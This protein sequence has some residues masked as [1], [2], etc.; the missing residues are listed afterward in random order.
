MSVTTKPSTPSPTIESEPAGDRFVAGALWTV[1]GLLVILQ[2]VAGEIIP[3]L[4]IAG[5]VYAGLGIL[6]ARR[7]SRRL[8]AAVI[9][10]GVIHLAGSA[11]FMLANLSHPE[12]TV[13]FLSEAFLGLAGMVVLIGAVAGLR[14]DRPGARRPIA[15]GAGLLAAAAVVVSLAAAS[16]VESEALGRGDVPV[17]TVRSAFP[18]IEVPAGGAVL[19]VDNQDP[20]H[21]TLVIE[22]TDVRAVLPG[23]TAVRVEVD[24][25]PGTYRYFCDVPGHDS[26][27][28]VLH[29]L[30]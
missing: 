5:L 29:V 2:V 7:R 3:P 8:L 25:E 28:G 6:L 13:S 27:E 14:T 19:W 4:A 10:L 20:I 23:S 26:M 12:S 21:H 15:I 1:A 24:L 22:G 30:P 18:D 9:V 11:P 17:E 16:G